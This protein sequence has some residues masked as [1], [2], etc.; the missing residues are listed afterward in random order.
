MCPIRQ[1]KKAPNPSLPFISH[2]TA[3]T[4][5]AYIKVIEISIT[6]QK[7]TGKYWRVRVT[8]QRVWASYGMDILTSRINKAAWMWPVIGADIHHVSNYWNQVQAV[9]SW[10]LNSEPCRGSPHK[11]ESEA[12]WYFWK[13]K[14]MRR[15]PELQQPER[16]CPLSWKQTKKMF[17]LN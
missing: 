8:I 3:S 10:S 14:C 5:L 15:E 4:W 16:L 13:Y 17:R 12:L 9:Q 6:Y 11:A 7:C 1:K 2:T